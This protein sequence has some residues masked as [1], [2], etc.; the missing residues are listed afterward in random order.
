MSKDG[1]IEGWTY[2]ENW[3]ENIKDDYSQVH[4]CVQEK[5]QTKHQV[6]V[7]EV[8]DL[9]QKSSPLLRPSCTFFWFYVFKLVHSEPT[10]GIL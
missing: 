1:M 4:R 9:D 7:A 8:Q 5:Y 10:V 3:R 2:K 6:W